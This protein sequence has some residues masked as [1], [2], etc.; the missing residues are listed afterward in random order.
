MNVN[1]ETVWSIEVNREGC[2]QAEVVLIYIAHPRHIIGV[3]VPKLSA[4]N[5]N[6]LAAILSEDALNQKFISLILA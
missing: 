3:L 1:I 5:A 6:A 2:H 4:S